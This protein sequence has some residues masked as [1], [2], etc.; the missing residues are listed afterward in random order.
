[1][2]KRVDNFDFSQLVAAAVRSGRWLDW[3]LIQNELAMLCELKEEPGIMAQ[4]IEL[5]ERTK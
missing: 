4:L 2:E 3:S 5:R 1:M